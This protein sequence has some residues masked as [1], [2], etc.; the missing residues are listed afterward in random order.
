M[1]TSLRILSGWGLQNGPICAKDMHS[2]GGGGGGT[3]GNVV[4]SSST[5]VAKTHFET[6]HLHLPLLLG[7]QGTFRIPCKAAGCLSR[8]IP[9]NHKDQL[10]IVSKELHLCKQ[11]LLAFKVV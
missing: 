5:S 10:L 9:P 2:V 8:P 3:R 6:L 1:L 11:L 4:G 7:R